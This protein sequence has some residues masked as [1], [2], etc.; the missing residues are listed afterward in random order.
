MGQIVQPD[1]ISTG[2]P[3]DGSGWVQWK[4]YR[5]QTGDHSVVLFGIQCHCL[6]WGVGNDQYWTFEADGENDM[7]EEN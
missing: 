5:D 1:D 6:N 3:T 4:G 2:D 7:S